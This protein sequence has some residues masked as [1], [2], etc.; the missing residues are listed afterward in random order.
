MGIL[1]TILF[2]TLK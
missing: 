2:Y 1:S